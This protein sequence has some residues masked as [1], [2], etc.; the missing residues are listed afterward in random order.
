MK[1]LTEELESVKAERNSLYEMQN[2]AQALVKE[3][4]ELQ[5]RV[6]S[7]GDE[8]EELQGRFSTLNGEKEELHEIVD[9]LRQEKQQLKAELEDRME[10]VCLIC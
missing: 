9:V 1:G 7:L 5:R 4:D 3:Q 6:I 2:D 8:K 10:M